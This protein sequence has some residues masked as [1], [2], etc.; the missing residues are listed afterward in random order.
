[1]KVS[2]EETFLYI[3]EMNEQIFFRNKKLISYLHP[4]IIYGLQ[5]VVKEVGN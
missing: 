2:G 4:I 1:M 3:K 5:G